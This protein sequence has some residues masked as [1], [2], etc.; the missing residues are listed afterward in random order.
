[1]SK[2]KKKVSHFKII[3]IAH[4]IFVYM[5]WNGFL[6]NQGKACVLRWNKL[7]YDVF[8]QIMI[9]SDLYKFNIYF[10]HSYKSVLFGEKMVVQWLLRLF[11][12]FDF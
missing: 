3:L 6:I 8:K 11:Y 4:N 1:M 5:N 10:K 12:N 9:F 2:E 7:T